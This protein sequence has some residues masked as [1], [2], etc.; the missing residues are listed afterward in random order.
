MG[1]KSKRVIAGLLSILMLLSV[2]P[3]FV[4]AD[5][6]TVE[7][8]ADVAGVELDYDALFES[9]YLINPAWAESLVSDAQL[10]FYFRGETKTVTYDAAK[11]FTS[12]DDAYAAWEATEPDIINDTPVFIF[13]PGTYDSEVWVRYRGIILGA[14]AGINPNDPSVDLKTIDP[15][16]G[17]ALNS[18][19][20]E[21]NET[22]FTA[23]VKRSTRVNGANDDLTL[24]GKLN[25]AEAGGAEMDFYLVVDGI[26]FQGT[27]MI[28]SDDVDVD[29]EKRPTV[30]GYRDSYLCLQNTRHS[31]SGETIF[32]QDTSMNR[33]TQHIKNLRQENVSGNLINKYANTII[34][35]GMYMTGQTSGD[36]FGNIDSNGYRYTTNIVFKN[37]YLYKNPVRYLGSLSGMTQNGTE[38]VEPGTIGIYDSVFY[39]AQSAAW[40]LFIVDRLP[41][42]WTFNFVG[43]TVLDD[44]TFNSKETK[45]T[46]M[47]G[48]GGYFQTVFN[49]NVTNN[50][51]IGWKT[52]LPN[53][54]A[55][56]SPE[57]L[58]QCKETWDFNNNYFAD[59]YTSEDDLG[60]TSVDFVNFALTDPSK[61]PIVAEELELY[62]DYKMTTLVSD[63]N[64][65]GLNYS[66]EVT[67]P[68]IDN[69]SRTINFGLSSG[70]LNDVG[71]TLKGASLTA[72]LYSDEG[73]ESEVTTLNADD[74]SEG[75]NTYYYGIYNAENALMAKYTV[76][77]TKV[78]S[79]EPFATAYDDSESEIKKTAVL[80][81]QRASDV[82][83]EGEYIYN[84]DGTYYSFTA[85]TN[86]FSTIA[87][88]LATEATQIILA[89]GEYAH[90]DITRGVSIYGVNYKVDPNVRYEDPF[91]DWTLSEQWNSAA[92]SALGNI[93]IKASVADDVLI[94]GVTMRGRFYDTERDFTNPDAVNI[95]I[96]NIVV[97]HTGIPEIISQSEVQAGGDESL[98]LINVNSIRAGNGANSIP[99]ENGK[100]KPGYEHLEESDVNDAAF[101]E[102]Y[103]DTF[104]LKNMRIENMQCASG[105]N[106]VIN[107]RT[108][109]VTTFDGLYINHNMAGKTAIN[110]WNWGK[111]GPNNKNYQFILK[112]S[113]VRNSTVANLWTFEARNEDQIESGKTFEIIFENNVFYDAFGTGT[114]YILR[115]YPWRTSKLH[116]NG[117]YMYAPSS[118]TGA[119]LNTQRQGEISWAEIDWNDTIDISARDNTIIGSGNLNSMNVGTGSNGTS[120]TLI[121]RTGNYYAPYTE[122]YLNGTS[123]TAPGGTATYDYYYLNFK[124]TVKNTDLGLAAVEAGTSDLTDVVFD[125]EGNKITA[126]LESGDTDGMII[127]S[128]S[129]EVFGSYTIYS[130][131]GLNTA[132]DNNII[133]SEMIGGTV[134]TY[135]VVFEKDG[136]QQV[137]NFEITGGDGESFATSYVDET[138]TIDAA[139]A[140]MLNPQAVGVESSGAEVTAAW[141]GVPYKFTV[142]TNIFATMDEIYAA[143]A[144]SDDKIQVLLA[145]QNYNE[146]VIK[147]GTEVYG[148]NW[149]TNPNVKGANPEDDWDRNPLW[150]QYGTTTVQFVDIVNYFTDTEAAAARPD[151]ATGITVKGI[152]LKGYFC[153]IDRTEK[154]DLTVENVLA[155]QDGQLTDPKVDYINNNHPTH[156]FRVGNTVNYTGIYTD[157]TPSTDKGLFKNIRFER[158]YTNSASTTG[159]YS[160]LFAEYLPAQTTFDGLY[161]NG[162]RYNTELRLFGY[163]KIGPGVTDGYFTFINSMIREPGTQYST[164]FFELEAKAKSPLGVGESY[165]VKFENN[166]FYNVGDGGDSS[167]DGVF[168][169]SIYP[170][171]I[172]SF[173]LIDNMFIDSRGTE[174]NNTRAIIAANN[175][176]ADETYP[177]TFNF[178]GNTIVG[179]Y[180]GFQIAVGS[181][182]SKADFVFEDN[183][184]AKYYTENY[185]TDKLGVAPNYTGLGTST[186]NSYWLD[187]ERTMSSG[188]IYDYAFSGEGLTVNEGDKTMSMSY[189]Y[190]TS[191]IDFS[192][193]ITS[194]EYNNQ[195]TAQTSEGEAADISALAVPAEEGEGATYKIIVSSPDG[196]AETPEEWTLTL[197]RG[198][199]TEAEL[200]G[201]AL[202]NSDQDAINA[203]YIEE[204]LF[205]A[206]LEDTI[207]TIPV[208]MASC[209]KNATW[210]LLY[211]GEPA[212]N[213]SGI[214]LGSSKDYTIRVTA[215]DGVTTKDFTLRVYRLAGE[216]AD[217]TLLNEQIEKAEAK[218]EGGEYS[219]ATVS[220]LEAVIA[221]A[222]IA[223]GNPSLTESAMEAQI[224]AL[225]TAMDALV[226]ISELND[227]I[228][229]A[230]AA[231]EAA[232]D[233]TASSLAGL[234]EPLAAAEQAAAKA[235]TVGEVTSA[236]TALQTAI[237]AL[238][239]VSALKAKIAEADEIDTSDYSEASVAE[240]E[241]KLAAAKLAVENATTQ[242][243]VT[244]ALNEL[245]EA[246][247]GLSADRSGLEAAIA[248]A[249]AKQGK[250]GYEYYTEATKTAVANALAAAEGLA[251]NAG[252]T[253]VDAAAA[254]LNTAVSGLAV[255]TARF[256]SE[257]AAYEAISNDDG[258][259]TE[260]SYEALQEAIAAARALEDPTVAQIADAIAALESVELVEADTSL[261]K[262]EGA[263][264]EAENKLK[265]DVDDA[266]S[267][268]LAIEL[269]KAERIEVFA[270][271]DCKVAIAADAELTLS[272]KTTRVYIRAYTGEE[273]Y[274]LIT[275][276]IETEIASVEYAD[277][278]PAWAN[279]YVQYLNK[280][281]YGI[282]IGDEN[283]NF[284]PKKEMTRY[285]IAVV[286]AKLLGVD[287]SKFASVELEFEDNIA[288]WASN[289]VKAVVT[290]GMMS[291]NDNGG[292]ITFDGQNPT[293][294]QQF[295]RIMAEAIRIL[296]NTGKD[297]VEL[298]NE[299]KAAIDKEYEAKGFADESSVQSWAKPYVRLAVVEYELLSGSPADGKLYINGN[300]NILRQEISVV[301]A[302]YLGCTD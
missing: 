182:I 235:T 140:V 189:A 220:A 188:D 195:I 178:I 11:H 103:A 141:D 2:M 167:D 57:I 150:D 28:H 82:A 256:E 236:N 102:T 219:A 61:T 75:A 243:A 109:A 205:A 177:Y 112:N 277:E 228:A 37:S 217:P 247:E 147:N 230:K 118:F 148:S 156:V 273:S 130:D 115:W 113:N 116:I 146:L 174:D 157:G 98:Y 25:S 175:V 267:Y 181:T 40:G 54:D 59:T 151:K 23:Q 136:V 282:L 163:S 122:D 160:R 42:G 81:D 245:V 207:E 263:T 196:N 39:E 297:P 229:E 24:D 266:T 211:N 83:A 215:E 47:S 289:Y 270:D 9:A 12:Y 187:F 170:K 203:D 5:T 258:K 120:A 293:Q 73:L 274:E 155:D 241:E 134:K 108:P 35:D 64:V 4:F 265:V 295:A 16:A 123:M 99:M 50:R 285:E 197:T 41:E 153:D 34:I 129:P 48:N 92:P 159:Y 86:V 104:T 242:A 284:N 84:F 185:R 224:T 161:V 20:S 80:V 299:N 255:D 225:Q 172:S 259:Y 179:P 94:K 128:V 101:G 55:N 233:Y 76:T 171:C 8:P 63:I 192:Q 79:A 209:S 1:R 43:N 300:S 131:S 206:Y 114:L 30:K 127:T 154:G 95:T 290:L 234:T 301:L 110:Y 221:E 31:G 71:I 262:I 275:L 191:S 119:L 292:R 132:V 26:N 66:S 239:N 72:K 58:E 165:P 190:G 252:Q 201:V 251:E 105:G 254:A 276:E 279:T 90:T 13:A 88:A 232:E 77:I 93:V 68:Y 111:A 291:G 238:V 32:S 162:A 283:S 124:R 53:M 135:Y 65:T 208:Y 213:I 96:E 216:P 214:E 70:T 269:V 21:E 184:F 281:G 298:Y 56:G 200:L 78:S 204:G 288:N 27:R 294:R 173:D 142:G 44:N 33:I 164:R 97:E 223:A 218:L 198:A 38:E 249:E 52:F 168:I 6:R 69:A 202:G 144:E 91:A 29:A 62:A 231:Q 133:T 278:I 49:W 17:W 227:A 121:D 250:K 74:L 36:I 210:Q 199:S 280:G 212:E 14:N 194:N 222:K 18:E 296:E 15:K 100:P 253:A 272:Q 244:T 117:N 125:K 22:V 246:I 158:I 46:A 166:V 268:K 89:P 193:Y 19:W 257:V 226:D 302:K 145:A 85:G 87:D 137:I 176:D 126:R 51:F 261:I 107:E 149:N 3:V 237:D 10:E 67:T 45:S 264:E 152:T 248:A 138:G 169:I 183:Y 286:A 186:V 106:R 143:K 240:F 180:N 7:T 60:N 287:A 139:T 271:P 260:E